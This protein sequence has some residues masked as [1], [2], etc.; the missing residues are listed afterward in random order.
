[1]TDIVFDGGRE[2]RRRH[3]EV[4]GP[5]AKPQPQP[6]E[7]NREDHRQRTDHDREPFDP[8]FG[9]QPTVQRCEPVTKPV[10]AGIGTG[11]QPPRAIARRLVVL[12]IRT[13]RV[14][15]LRDLGLGTR[16][17]PL[18][19]S[20][21][22]H[23]LSVPALRLIAANGAPIDWYRALLCRHLCQSS[24]ITVTRGRTQGLIGRPL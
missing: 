5:G 18:G 23:C 4:D 8:P 24:I 13:S 22:S 21:P 16:I 15:P 11:Q 6:A 1:M 7:A 10:N 3:I 19:R 14:V 2:P 12:L 20:I 17:R 9:S